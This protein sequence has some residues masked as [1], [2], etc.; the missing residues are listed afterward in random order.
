MKGCHHQNTSV[1]FVCLDTVYRNGK[2]YQ[3]HSNSIYNV[4]F[5][6]P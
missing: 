6:E 1:N 5:D 4:M 3:V 2:L